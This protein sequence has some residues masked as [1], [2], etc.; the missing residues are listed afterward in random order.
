MKKLFIAAFLIFTSLSANISAQK[1]EKTGKISEMIAAANKTGNLFSGLLGGVFPDSENAEITNLSRINFPASVKVK[2][3]GETE[4]I[5]K[6]RKKAIDKW[7][8]DYAEKSAEKKF[9][10]NQIAAEEDG[11][12]YW[13]MAHENSVMSKLKAT[14][15]DDEI[16]LNLR[17]IGYYKKGKTIDYFL[18]ADGVK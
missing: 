5:G 9:Y 15:K 6:P 17:V 2:Y 11:K 8:K 14:E 4:K 3:L 10:V 13:I 12:K 16:I 7:L 18:V 1:E